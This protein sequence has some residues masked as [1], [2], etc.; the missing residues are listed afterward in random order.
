MKYLLCLLCALITGCSSSK[1]LI[2]EN[3]IDGWKTVNGGEWTVEN[4]ILSGSKVAE[5]SKHCLLVSDQE[6]SNFKLD[7]EYKAING[8][9]GFDLLLTQFV[10]R[11][12]P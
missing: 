1:S 3:S 5:I 6:F 8:N 12:R 4:G 10:T 11:T 7:I 2:K 9:S